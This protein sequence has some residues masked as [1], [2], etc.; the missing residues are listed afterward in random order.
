MKYISVNFPAKH[1][2]KQIRRK[3]RIVV[4]HTEGDPQGLGTLEWWKTRKGGKGTVCTPYLIRQDGDILHLFDDRYWSYAFGLNMPIAKSLEMSTIHI[5][6]ACWGGVVPHPSGEGFT[7]DANKSLRLSDSEVI[8]YP[9]PWRVGFRSF[10]KYSPAQI[11][12]LVELCRALSVK[13]GIECEYRY[14]RFFSLNSD[15]LRGAP[16]LYSH[17]AFRLDKAD[18]HPQP[19]L[20]QAL[21]AAF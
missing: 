3:T 14:D 2:Y 4:H 8:T 9:E 7:D 6:L 17:A 13:H 19:E 10:H 18:L 20:I 21:S 16:G 11:S 5:E 12:S 15:A 1:Y